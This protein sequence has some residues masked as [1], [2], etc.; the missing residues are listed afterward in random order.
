MC[1]LL[2]PTPRGREVLDRELAARSSFP[3]EQWTKMHIGPD[4]IRPFLRAIRDVADLPNDHLMPEDS[5]R[6]ILE[7]CGI[8][9]AAEQIMGMFEWLS[10]RDLAADV[11][12]NAL[13]HRWTL[14]RTVVEMD[15]VD[16]SRLGGR[17][18]SS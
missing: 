8:D 13:D 4:Q 6:F 3:E 11:L 17:E 7:S 1:W 18:A 16:S 2:V 9:C 14:G 5:L 10:S 15:L 12:Q